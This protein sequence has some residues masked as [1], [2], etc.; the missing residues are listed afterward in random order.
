MINPKDCEECSMIG[1]KGT[2]LGG[3]NCP[4]QVVVDDEGNMIVCD[5]MNHR[6]Q[7]V[8]ES[9]RGEE[10]IAMIKPN[11]DDRVMQLNTFSLPSIAYLDTRREL[12]YV[13]NKLS[14]TIVKYSL[15][16]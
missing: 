9:E 16:A 13:G 10:F 15:T 2:G 11:Q 8:R 3:F 14:R 5:A 7:V 6:L 12:L 1:H 4:A